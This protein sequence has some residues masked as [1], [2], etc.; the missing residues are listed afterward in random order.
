MTSSKFARPS[1]IP[2]ALS[3]SRGANRDS[4]SYLLLPKNLLKR[5]MVLDSGLSDATESGAF[6]AEAVWKALRRVG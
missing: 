2:K 5:L 4:G 3:G 1:E 6:I